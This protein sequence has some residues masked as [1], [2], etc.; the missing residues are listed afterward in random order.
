[1][2]KH[3]C[4]P[5]RVRGYLAAV[6]LSCL[7]LFWMSCNQKNQMAT[8]PST[9]LS[10]AKPADGGIES[11]D[12][13]LLGTASSFAVLGGSTVTSTG[14][15]LVTG[16]LGVWSGTAITG[17][18]PGI[19]IGTIRAGDDVA[20]QA[21]SDLTTAYNLLAGLPCNTD[22]TGQDLGGKT[23]APGV[24]CFSSS[25]QLTG[26]LFLDAQGNSNAVF[27]FQIASTLT[28]ASNSSVVMMNGGRVCNV[29]WQVGSSST[30]GT[31][32]VFAGNIL[33]LASITLTTG[34]NLSG[35][36][37]SRTG[38]VTMDTDTVSAAD[39]G[40]GPNG[41]CRVKVT[42]G[43]SIPVAG[44]FA[45]F[46]FVVQ[47]KKD[48]RIKG[49]LQYKNHAS[50]T[51]IRIR[52]FTSLLIVGKTATFAGSGTINRVPGSFTV[53]VTDKGEPGRNDQFSISISGGPTEEGTLR[54]GN[55]QIHEKNCGERDGNDN[56][57]NDDNDDDDDDDD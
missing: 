49:K 53:T 9:D 57:H 10:L 11:A 28:T 48:G 5:A 56:G 23:L 44:G 38:A 52:E 35:R 30:L 15:S 46:G 31:G 55:I 22:L 12:F 43:G 19:V 4:K 20:A 32:T 6:L 3:L 45:N 36:A 41:K 8:N 25:A 26:T 37:L 17:F 24:Y 1:M 42:G 2:Y 50:G 51:K 33:A 13:P 27:I 18:P 14:L 29:F 21:Q 34:V 7:A 54:S 16:D 47:Q 40:Q 39:C